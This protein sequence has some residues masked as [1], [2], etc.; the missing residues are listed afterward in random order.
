MPYVR[1]AS[2]CLSVLRRYNDHRVQQHSGTIFYVL[3]RKI[4]EHCMQAVQYYWDKNGVILSRFLLFYM[5]VQS[6]ELFLT[7]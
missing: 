4:L 1:Y 5:V 7:F 3:V 2:N 6:R